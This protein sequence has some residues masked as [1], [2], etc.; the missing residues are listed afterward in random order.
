M[1]W[2]HPKRHSCSEVRANRA[3]MYLKDYS[4]RNRAIMSTSPPNGNIS[5]D[6]LLAPLWKQFCSLWLNI[7]C[8]SESRAPAKQICTST[9]DLFPHNE[10]LAKSIKLT[11]LKI[12][13]RD[14][15]VT[16]PKPPYRKMGD[17]QNNGLQL[18][19]RNYNFL[20]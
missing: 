2:C 15:N 14:E 11:A 13:N 1:V 12:W 19:E 20:S 3:C 8:I 16:R 10:C 4:P 7:Y 18:V 17:G 6:K 5:P 9:K